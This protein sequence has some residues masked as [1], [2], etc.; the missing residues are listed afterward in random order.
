MIDSL[1]MA[2]IFA[3]CSV[4]SGSFWSFQVSKSLVFW[5]TRCGPI[6][7]RLTA[8]QPQAEQH[9]AAEL[10]ESACRRF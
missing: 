4:G 5:E 3:G 2:T 8:A 6:A 10:D 7:Q 9:Q 1:Q